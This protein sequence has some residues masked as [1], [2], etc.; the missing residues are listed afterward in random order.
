MTRQV[1]NTWTELWGAQRGLGRG[2]GYAEQQ[3]L[4]LVSPLAATAAWR[5]TSPATNRIEVGGRLQ[6]SSFSAGLERM[7][8]TMWSGHQLA[9]TWNGDHDY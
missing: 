3:W 2:R 8:T 9:A 6:F 7:G 4:R 5:S 1:E